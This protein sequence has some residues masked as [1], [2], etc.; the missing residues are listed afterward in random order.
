MKVGELA[1][2]ELSFFVS[3][4]KELTT[5]RL[6]SESLDGS[7]IAIG[8]MVEQDLD[9]HARLRSFVHRCDDVVDAAA[10]DEADNPEPFMRT[11]NY[12]E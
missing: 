11:S 10:E 12:F 5:G 3:P 1:R 8:T 9:F 4:G 2:L 6:T 7:V